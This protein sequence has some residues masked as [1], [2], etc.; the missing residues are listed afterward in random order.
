MPAAYLIRQMAYYKAG[1]R[2]DDE[3]MGPIAKVTSD[4]DIRQAAEYF[5]ALKPA[6]G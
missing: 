2:K 6:C 3:R 1:T 4:E 5:A